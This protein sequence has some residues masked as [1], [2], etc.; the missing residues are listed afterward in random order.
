MIF[1]TSFVFISL[2][3]SNRYNNEKDSENSTDLPIPRRRIK[4]R[5]INLRSRSLSRRRAHAY[6]IIRIE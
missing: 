2:L 1:A 3:I 6:N 5:I 4:P